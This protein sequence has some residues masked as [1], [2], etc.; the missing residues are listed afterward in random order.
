MVSFMHLKSF[1]LLSKFKFGHI[2]LQPMIILIKVNYY[3]KHFALLQTEATQTAWNYWS[4]I[5]GTT[6]QFFFANTPCIFRILA[7]LERSNYYASWRS[8][9]TDHHKNCSTAPYKTNFI[10]Y[11]FQYELNVRLLFYDD[12]NADSPVLQCLMS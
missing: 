6:K 3:F 12:L 10:S 5:H 2:V 8:S 11:L 7:Y 4:K 9:Q 1:G